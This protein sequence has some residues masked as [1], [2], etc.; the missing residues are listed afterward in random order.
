MFKIRHLTCYMKATKAF[1][2]V[3]RKISVC[4]N[5][6][7]I[8]ILNYFIYFWHLEH[9][10]YHNSH[11]ACIFLRLAFKSVCRRNNRKQFAD[12]VCIIKWNSQC[13]AVCLYT[14][15]MFNVE[16]FLIKSSYMSVVV[17]QQRRI[18]FKH[19]SPFKTLRMW[20]NNFF[21]QLRQQHLKN[22]F[23][24]FFSCVEEKRWKL[25]RSATAEAGAKFDQICN[26]L[27]NYR[28][29]NRGQAE[30]RARTDSL[31]P[32]AA[33]VQSSTWDKHTMTKRPE[34]TP[35]NIRNRT[36]E[37]SSTGCLSTKGWCRW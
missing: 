33:R 7:I 29:S 2:H 4:Y 5:N 8:I 36:E 3:V 23:F 30:R 13:T 10:T 27:Q 18:R 14:V 32:K 34:M 12:C 28:V 20:Q 11:F 22:T 24:F 37:P 9:S 15:S 16:I 1:G 19:F 26:D 25:E 21:L 35:S 17:K 6:L 31:S